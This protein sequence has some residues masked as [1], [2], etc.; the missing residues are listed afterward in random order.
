[1]AFCS[2]C[3]AQ[4]DGRFCPKCGAPQE[5]PAGAAA[6]P[7]Q[8]AYAPPPPAQPVA[9]GGMEDN[10]AGALCYLLGFITGVLFLVLEP[11]N[12]R[13]FVRFHA[14]QAI[15]FSAGWIVLSIAVSI[16]LGLMSVVMHMWLVF[17]P[18]RMLIG[19][20]GFLLWLF[21]M[22]KAYNRELYQLPIVGPIAAR[23]AGS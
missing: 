4:V 2:S 22:Y 12:K 13:P 1:M 16:L 20:L 18:L 11:Y 10:M 3:G 21:C 7:P 9:A 14:F 8:P 19:L 23:Q 6:A 15:L 17:V 5:A